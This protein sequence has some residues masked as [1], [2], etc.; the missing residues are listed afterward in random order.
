MTR[1]PVDVHQSRL[2][3]LISGGLAAVLLAPK[4]VIF[5]QSD[6]STGGLAVI[7][8]LALISVYA[9]YSVPCLPLTYKYPDCT[10][11]LRLLHHL[12]CTHLFFPSVS[13]QSL[14]PTVEITMRLSVKQLLAALVAAAAATC[15]AAPV[16]APL[17]YFC[18]SSNV[19][20]RLRNH[21]GGICCIPSK[22]RIRQTSF[23]WETMGF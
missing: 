15:A 20:P 13:L 14:I 11:R 9:L 6:L 7:L 19:S 5:C 22:M 12:H 16:S 23:T 18:M 10:P 8:L 21:P 3:G 17:T 4:S 1:N 2:D